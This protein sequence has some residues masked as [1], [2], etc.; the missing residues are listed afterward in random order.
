MED[1][2]LFEKAT[3]L[4]SA[5]IADS[6]DSYGFFNHC[7]DPAIRPMKQDSVLMGRVATLVTADVYEVPENPYALEIEAVD[8]LKKDQVLV[9]KC[10]TTRYSAFWGGLLTNAAVGRGAR[11][12]MVDGYS[13]DCREILSLN[14]PVFC[15]GFTPYDS[16]GRQEGILRN[17]PIDFGGIQVKPGDF[18]YG[19][20]DGIVVVPKEQEDEVINAAWEKVQGESKVR[21][22]LKA[23]IS[24][25]KVFAKYRIL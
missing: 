21:E 8:A 24:V 23:G 6:L 10:S 18:I 11:G 17:V 16:K 3:G 4:Y 5:V 1:R 19:D 14:F 13:R 9:V 15:R 20:I 12:V 25:A 22:E 7:P 2:E